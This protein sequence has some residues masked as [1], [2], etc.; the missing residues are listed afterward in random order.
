M[1]YIFILFTA[2]VRLLECNIKLRVKSDGVCVKERDREG[3]EKVERKE[4]GTFLL[5]FYVIYLSCILLVGLFR[6]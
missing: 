5:L 3:E 1:P 6:F 2:Y 4:T